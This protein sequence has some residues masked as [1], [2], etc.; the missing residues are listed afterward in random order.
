MRGDAISFEVALFLTQLM[1]SLALVVLAVA[2]KATR[3]RLEQRRRTL[4]VLALRAT[5]PWRGPA[6]QRERDIES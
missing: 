4:E 6:K 1:L 3:K 5:L 2:A